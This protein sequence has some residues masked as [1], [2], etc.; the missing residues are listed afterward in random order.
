MDGTESGQKVLDLLNAGIKS[1]VVEQQVL[2][3]TRIVSNKYAI[4]DSLTNVGKILK[5]SNIATYENVPTELMF[6]LPSDYAALSTID[7]L[8]RHY[9]W[10]KRFPTVLQLAE[11]KWQIN[12]EYDWGLWSDD[13][14]TFVT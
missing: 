7:G 4:K 5:A 12:L 8:T 13:L 14:Y 6:N 10:L 11:G 9:G 1:R 3:R 2:R